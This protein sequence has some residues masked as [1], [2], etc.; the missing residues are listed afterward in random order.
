MV[1]DM[2]TRFQGFF[3][4]GVSSSGARVAL[5][6]LTV[7]IRF[8]TAPSSRDKLNITLHMAQKL[9]TFFQVMPQ[10]MTC[11]IPFGQR[12]HSHDGTTTS[13]QSSNLLKKPLCGVQ[14][15][16]VGRSGQRLEHCYGLRSVERAGSQPEWPWSTRLCSV[17]H[18]M[19]LEL[20]T[21]NFIVVKANK[22]LQRLVEDAAAADPADCRSTSS[23]PV[24]SLVY[25]LQVH[26]L[27]VAWC[28]NN[29]PQYVEFL[30]G[31]LQDMTRSTLAATLETEQVQLVAQDHDNESP[32]QM[33]TPHSY[34][35]EL[36]EKPARLRRIASSFRSHVD[37]IQT[38]KSERITKPAMPSIERVPVAQHT[39]SFKDLPRIHFLE[40]KV[41]EAVDVLENNEEVLDDL[42][43]DYE[44]V[45]AA[46]LE[47]QNSSECEAALAQFVKIIAA[48]QRDM[49]RQRTRLERILK[50]LASRK[51]LVS[52]GIM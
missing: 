6:D 41:N 46:R 12:E 14:V 10:F 13:F 28:G 27:I 25:A 16:S 5:L 50:L 15:T 22:L 18:S 20:G 40:E 39:F 17:Y 32:T 48:V 52:R 43:C 7:A 26:G 3:D 36:D 44:L 9:F 30:A 11:I 21:S 29:W 2:Q 4:N 37:R 1:P 31:T 23:I 49:R 45:F 38:F 47:L 35:L 33:S 19:D 34:D 51:A 24:L 42:K 8:I